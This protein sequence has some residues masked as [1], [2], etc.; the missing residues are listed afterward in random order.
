MTTNTAKVIALANN[1]V[2]QLFWTYPE[3][4]K[5]CLGFAVFRR[6]DGTTGAWD[7]LPAWVGFKGQSNKAWQSQ[8]TTV[9]PI[10]KFGWKDLTATRGKTYHYR[11]VPVGGKPAVGKPLTPIGTPCETQIPVTLTPV[12]GA[13]LSY[14]NRGILST[15]FLVHQVPAGPNGAPNYKTLINRIDQP[16]DPLRAALAGQILDGL[17]YLLN[18]A[19]NKGGS[20]YAALYELT[21]PELLQALLQ[22]KNLHL[23]LSNTG[24]D[25]SENKPARQALHETAGIEILDRFVPSGHIGHN[26][27]CVYVDPQ[28]RAQQVLLGSTNWTDTGVCAQSNNALIAQNPEI[29]TAY[30][31]YWERLKTD[32]V[33]AGAKQATPLRSADAK[34]GASGVPV[35][36]GKATVW[37]SPNTPK[38]R[39][40]K[41]PKNEPTPVDLQDVFGLMDA[42]KKAILFLE[43]QPGSPSVVDRGRFPA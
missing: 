24:T 10:Q 23:I 42:A 8:P 33:K 14:F 37:F 34:P 35:D 11:I 1:D 25:D 31:A 12:R 27:F 2:V 6:E 30:M 4:I 39:S 20:L 18:L 21:D 16:G 13:F 36:E 38:Q 32:T 19:A 22:S 5:G 41:P 29:A 28:G 17:K 9:W 26:K 15:Q 43:F 40:S 3:A 7:P